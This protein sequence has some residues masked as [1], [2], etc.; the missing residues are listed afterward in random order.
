M[1]PGLS[2]ISPDRYIRIREILKD[3]NKFDRA[4]RISLEKNVEFSL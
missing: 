2:S 1:G 4:K 3:M